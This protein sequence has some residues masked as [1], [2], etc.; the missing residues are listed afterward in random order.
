VFGR[1]IQFNLIDEFVPL[2]RSK[3]QYFLPEERTK[4]ELN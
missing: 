1:L 3:L 2:C 4:R